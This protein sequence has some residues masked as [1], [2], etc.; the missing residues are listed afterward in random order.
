MCAYYYINITIR[1][2]MKIDSPANIKI[3]LL[4]SHI[5]RGV[6]CMAYESFMMHKSREMNRI[7][8]NVKPARSEMKP[9]VRMQ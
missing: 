7:D 5:F 3:F 9:L 8:R 4:H 2:C 1:F 6:M